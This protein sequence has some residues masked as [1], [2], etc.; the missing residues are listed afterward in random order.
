[1][2]IRHWPITIVG[3]TLLFATLG[4]DWDDGTETSNDTNINIDTV[5]AEDTTEDIGVTP[6]IAV[7]LDAIEDTT[8]PEDVASPVD[9]QN[10]EDT[11][12][13]IDATIADTIEVEDIDEQ[14]DVNELS[15]VNI[16]EDIE[17]P[18]DIAVSVPDVTEVP[19]VAVV[20]DAGSETGPKAGDPCIH[21][22]FDPAG[23]ICTEEPPYEVV[24]VCDG[25][26][27]VDPKDPEA[28]PEIGFCDC[29]EAPD[30]TVEVVC[31]TPGFVGIS[32]ANQERV[33][34]TRLRPTLS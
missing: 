4:C 21:G 19:D 26:V 6:D 18:E 9:T 5:V 22:F 3:G 1:M 17:E 15:D 2:R 24:L 12:Q 10:T 7:P 8:A 32:V 23:V 20:E 11:A 25:E 27:Y 30:G 14:E 29:W 13:P 16:A 33:I 34:T 28:S 31:A